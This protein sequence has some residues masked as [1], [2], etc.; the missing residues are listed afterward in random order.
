MLAGLTV[1]LAVGAHE[2]S[3]GTGPSL[4]VT[5]VGFL[6]TCRVGWGVTARRVSPARLVGLVLAIQVCLHVAFAMSAAG[7]AHHPASPAP[8]TALAVPG[9][10]RVEL[11]HGGLPVIAGHVLAALFLAGWLAAGE[12]LL[13]RAARGAAS[14]ARRAARRLRCRPAAFRP[15]AFRPPPAAFP[16]PPAVRLLPLRHAIARRGPPRPAQV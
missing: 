7:H 11:F 9:H 15:S 10:G 4:P 8:G 6:L 13:W 1:G 3:T 5:A 12:R 16:H 14:A 2:V